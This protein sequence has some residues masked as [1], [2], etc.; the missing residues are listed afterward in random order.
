MELVANAST[1][2]R[3]LTYFDTI[4]LDEADLRIGRLDPR[5]RASNGP[6]KVSARLIVDLLEAAAAATQQSDFGLRYGVWLNLRGLD[7]LSLL[8]EQA[9]SIAQWYQ[10]AQRYVHL[11]NNALRYDTLSDGEDIGLVHDVLAVL[12]PRATQAT[13]TFITLTARVFREV[14]GRRWSPVRLELRCARPADETLLQAFFRCPIDFEA[15]RNVLW[16]RRADFERKLGSGNPQLLSFLEDHL[17][18]Q[19][20]DW[21]TRLEDNVFQMVAE[22]LAGH[23]PSLARIAGRLAMSPRTLQRRLAREGR[24]FGQVLE[25]VRLAVAATHLDRR[26]PTSLSKLAYELGFSDPTAASRFL[27]L[28]SRALSAAPEP[29]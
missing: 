27:R 15:P 29:T 12:Q 10:L 19:A 11:E 6:F 8:W 4:G 14:I 25:E 16:V 2:R 13:F 23:A 17:R 28:K 18:R 5:L 24:T 9:G 26:P 20:I 7:T 3:L 1:V 22:D 21:S